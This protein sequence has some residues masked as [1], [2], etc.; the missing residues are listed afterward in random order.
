[1]PPVRNAVELENVLLARLHADPKF[2]GVDSSQLRT[3]LRDHLEAMVLE[4]IIPE[5]SVILDLRGWCRGMAANIS[6]E[7]GTAGQDIAMM[8]RRI[9]ATHL[10]RPSHLEPTSR[11]RRAPVSAFLTALG[12]TPPDVVASVEDEEKVDALKK[13]ALHMSLK[14]SLLDRLKDAK[15]VVE[16]AEEKVE[17][18][19]G[20]KRLV[21]LD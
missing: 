17:L 13:M 11:A 9:M 1:M 21:E 10:M 20:F 14:P 18:V 7:M 6:F 19:G 8:C 12:R 16:D 15:K 2:F 3:R 4:G 5:E